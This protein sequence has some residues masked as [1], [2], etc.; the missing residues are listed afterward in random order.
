MLSLIAPEAGA[1]F[2]TQAISLE[3]GLAWVYILGSEVYTR[4]YLGVQIPLKES[5]DLLEE[6][7]KPADGFPVTY[8]LYS[9]EELNSISFPANFLQDKDAMLAGASAQGV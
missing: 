7:P 2:Q 5:E 9:L 4:P 1:F 3:E 6:N 8:V